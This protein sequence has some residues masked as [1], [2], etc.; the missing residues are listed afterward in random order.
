MFRRYRDS[1]KLFVHVQNTLRGF[2]IQCRDCEDGSYW[3][4]E[5]S[6]SVLSYFAGFSSSAGRTRSRDPVSNFTQNRAHGSAEALR[7]ARTW[8][9]DK[10][11]CRATLA[12]SAIHATQHAGHAATMHP[13]FLIKTCLALKMQRYRL[14]LTATGGCSAVS[15]QHVAPQTPETAPSCLEQRFRLAAMRRLLH[16]WSYHLAQRFGIA[17]LS[18]AD[19]EWHLRPPLAAGQKTGSLRVSI[20]GSRSRSGPLLQTLT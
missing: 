14:Q 17:C 11:L 5:D 18:A 19:V 20:C 15:V 16:K 13:N 7:A 1:F 2:S 8:R 10:V 3:Q 4:L 9:T 12:D 6:P